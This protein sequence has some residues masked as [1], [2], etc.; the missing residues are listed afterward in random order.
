MDVNRRWCWF[1]IP[2]FHCSACFQQAY[3]HTR[4]PT[5]AHSHTMKIC[6]GKLGP[7]WAIKWDLPWIQ[8]KRIWVCVVF[9]SILV[10]ISVD[11]ICSHTHTHNQQS[12]CSVRKAPQGPCVLEKT[13]RTQSR[14]QESCLSKL[15]RWLIIKWDLHSVR[16]RPKEQACG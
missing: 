10:G 12:A 16:Q 3:T 4:T 5:H 9:N 13:Q 7:W 11:F 2:L 6:H 1:R 8:A 15:G 14:S